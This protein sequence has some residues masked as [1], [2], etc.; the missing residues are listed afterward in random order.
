M[1]SNLPVSN[2]DYRLL[3]ED[4]ETGIEGGEEAQDT[5][6]KS[7]TIARMSTHH[8]NLQQTW[9]SRALN[10]MLCA[11]GIMVCYGAFSVFQEKM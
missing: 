6:G 9:Q 4:E 5:K 11:G 1:S 2:S 10:L 3:L 7:T 8:R